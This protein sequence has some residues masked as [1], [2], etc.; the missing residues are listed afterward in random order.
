MRRLGPGGRL[1][2]V[3]KQRTP[4]RSKVP[5]R[6]VQGRG[7]PRMIR[8]LP[9]AEV[10]LLGDRVELLRKERAWTQEDLAAR[11]DTTSHLI[12]GIE[13]ATKAVYFATAVRVAEA[14]GCSLDYL[15]GRTNDPRITT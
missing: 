11:A 4:I 7:R 10:R 6:P 9:L 1:P 5:L 2:G 14:L 3:G 8:P 13:R 12:S 15:A